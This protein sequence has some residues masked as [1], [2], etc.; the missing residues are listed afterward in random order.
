MLAAVAGLEAVGVF[1]SA[2]VLFSPLNVLLQAVPMVGIPE[3]VRLLKRRPELFASSWS[4]E[5]P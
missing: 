3:G 4:P 1:R 5:G 2:Q